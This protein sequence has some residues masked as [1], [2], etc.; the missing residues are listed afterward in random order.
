MGGCPILGD[1]KLLGFPISGILKLLGCPIFGDSKL[2]GCPLFGD[3]KLLGSPK[4][5]DLKL[6]GCPIISDSS[7]PD[8]PK[9][10]ELTCFDKF[11]MGEPIPELCLLL[12]LSFCHSNCLIWGE[13]MLESALASILT[14]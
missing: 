11:C 13:L 12:T 14:S 5:G 4:F 10:G 7:L 2:L 9:F 6:L 3:L 1:S 8:S